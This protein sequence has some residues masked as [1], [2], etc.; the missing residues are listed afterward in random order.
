SVETVR[1]MAPGNYETAFSRNLGLVTPEEQ[2]RLRSS[3]VAIAGLGGGGGVHLVTLLRMGV[4]RFRIAD[5]DSF[6]LANMNRQ[7]GATIDTLGRSK[8]EVMAEVARSIQ[9]DVE[10]ELF[11]EG[12]TPGNCDAFLQGAQVAVDAIDFFAMETRRM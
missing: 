8:I 5:H 10:I 3:C 12:I 1:A 2:E 7:Y 6:E 4:G 9:P 11:P